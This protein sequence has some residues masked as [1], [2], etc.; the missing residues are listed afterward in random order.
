MTTHQSAAVLSGIMPDYAMAGVV[1]SR[2]EVYVTADDSIVSGDTLQMVPVPIGAK[3]LDV[4]VYHTI[5]EATH[6]TVIDVGYGGNGNA[7]LTT[8]ATAVRTKSMVGTIG[9][10]APDGF[11]HIFTADDT[12][13]I[14]F[15]KT[16][17]KIPTSQHFKMTVIYKMTGTIADESS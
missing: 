2:D 10:T 4:I 7:F 6:G 13:D 3:I 16:N 12:I 17:T 11:L 5:V 8:T 14:S 9:A 1:L 15:P